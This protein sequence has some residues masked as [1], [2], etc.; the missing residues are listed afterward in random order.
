LLVVGADVEA[1]PADFA[2]DLANA[3]GVG[4]PVE[5][6]GILIL[7][8]LDERPTEVVTQVGITVPGSAIADSARTFF[9]AD[10]FEGGLLAIVESLDAMVAAEPEAA[11]PAGSVNRARSSSLYAMGSA[12]SISKSST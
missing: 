8:S 3:W 4:D 10:D 11:P 7:V 2:V 1:N 6:N 12:T 5:E 9:S